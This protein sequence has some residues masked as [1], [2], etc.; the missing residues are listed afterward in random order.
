MEEKQV[1]LSVNISL[2][3][4]E[5]LDKYIQNTQQ[6]KDDVVDKAIQKYLYKPHMFKVIDPEP[7]RCRPIKRTKI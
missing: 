2:S 7:D 3:T 5:A 4:D 1:T 6:N